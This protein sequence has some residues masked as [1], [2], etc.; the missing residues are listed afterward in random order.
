MEPITWVGAATTQARDEK[1]GIIANVSGEFN[2]WIPVE[3][4]ASYQTKS[5]CSIT[6]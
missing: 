4:V 5:L 2:A 3:H 6:H 1:G